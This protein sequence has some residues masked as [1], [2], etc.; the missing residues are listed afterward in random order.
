[1]ARARRLRAVRAPAEVT[2]GEAAGEIVCF[3]ASHHSPGR[4]RDAGQSDSRA[5][6]KLV[7]SRG[8]HRAPRP[9][10]ARRAPGRHPP[11]PLCRDAA[12]IRAITTRGRA[13]AGGDPA[14]TD[15]SFALLYAYL[16]AG[17][18]AISGGSIAFARAVQLALGLITVLVIR[19]G[20]RDGGERAALGGAAWACIRSPFAWKAISCSRGRSLSSRWR[21]SSS[22]SALARPSRRAWLATG[23]PRPGGDHPSQHPRL[24]GALAAHQRPRPRPVGGEWRPSGADQYRSGSPAPARALPRSPRWHGCARPPLAHPAGVPAQ[25]HRRRD[26]TPIAT[27]AGADPTSA[28]I[29]DPTASLPSS[30]ARGPRGGAGTMTRSTWPSAAA[31]AASRRPRWTSTGGN[32]GSSAGRTTRRPR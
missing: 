13:I 29:R 7:D 24:R 9:G 31:S 18:Y 14:S 8:S 25:R 27:Q 12:W 30:P 23:P 10:R 20:R 28:T 21:P 5:D 11:D 6:E 3:S 22:T 4:E 15:P 16:S 2:T 26:F 32:R 17:W 1:M 19:I